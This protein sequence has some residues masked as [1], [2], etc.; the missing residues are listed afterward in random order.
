MDQILSGLLQTQVMQWGMGLPSWLIVA[1][2][3]A[4]LVAFALL[5]LFKDRFN[6]YGAKIGITYDQVEPVV[7]TLTMFAIQLFVM[8]QGLQ[9]SRR[10]NQLRNIAQLIDATYDSK[11]TLRVSELVYAMDKALKSNEQDLGIDAQERSDLVKDMATRIVK[12]VKTVGNKV[13]DDENDP[14]VRP[15]DVSLWINNTIN[16]IHKTKQRQA[17]F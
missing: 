12:E 1:F 5:F 11:S 2:L 4:C 17:R 15:T 9:E 8:K 3:V 6:K 7:K 14:I 10:I 13:N 16:T